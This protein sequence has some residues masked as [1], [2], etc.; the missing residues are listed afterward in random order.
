MVTS[1]TISK[2]VRD[3]LAKLKY[4]LNCKDYNE[5][6]LKLLRNMRKVKGDE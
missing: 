6:I 3:E 1:I 2:Q 5:V 4:S